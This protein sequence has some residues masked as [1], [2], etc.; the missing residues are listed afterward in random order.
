MLI[1]NAFLWIE[2]R[3]VHRNPNPG[4]NLSFDMTVTSAAFYKLA[5][6]VGYSHSSSYLV[7]NYY[8]HYR[9]LP[10]TLTAPTVLSTS[11]LHNYA[12][13]VYIDTL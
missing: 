9:Y 13:S 10:Q 1:L 6:F 8:Y 11:A 2:L 4:L 7:I 5:C 3:K 12:H